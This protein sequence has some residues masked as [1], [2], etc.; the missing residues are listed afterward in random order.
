MNSVKLLNTC[1]CIIVCRPIYLKR[2]F[3]D[4]SLDNGDVKPPHIDFEFLRQTDFCQNLVCLPSVRLC[5][6]PPVEDQF[7]IIELALD[8]EQFLS[9]YIGIG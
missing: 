7:Q 4:M 9:Y 8:A 5:S 1:F 3:S 6:F 2:A